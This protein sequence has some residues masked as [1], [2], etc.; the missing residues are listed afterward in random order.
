MMGDT[1]KQLF[2]VAAI[3]GISR[4]EPAAGRLPLVTFFLTMKLMVTSG[5][6]L[7]SSARLWAR[8]TTPALLFIVRMPSRSRVPSFENMNSSASI[9]PDLPL[10]LGAGAEN[11]AD[12]RL[13]RQIGSLAV[14]RNPDILAPANVNDEAAN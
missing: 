11:G 13:I 12:R 3:S 8:A 7:A 14:K 1:V 4:F 2:T 5:E 6:S 9:M 10:P